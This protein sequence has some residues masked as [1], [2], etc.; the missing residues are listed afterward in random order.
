MSG[1]RPYAETERS[2]DLGSDHVV[3]MGRVLHGHASPRVRM[4]SRPASMAASS[5]S[6][7]AELGWGGSCIARRTAVGDP[8]RDLGT[9]STSELNRS[10]ASCW[11]LLRCAAA[12]PSRLRTTWSGTS[13]FKFAIRV[14]SPSDCAAWRKRKPSR[15]AVPDPSAA[16]FPRFGR[17]TSQVD[18]RK[19]EDA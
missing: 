2:G 9:T 11:M 18:S 8:A 10:R 5:S 12:I 6:T 17:Q 7:S 16:A 14:R 1:R 13:M 4:G 15:V 19:P 3:R